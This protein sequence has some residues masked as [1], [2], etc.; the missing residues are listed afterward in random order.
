MLGCIFEML[1]IGRYV[2]IFRVLFVIK[3]KE[4]FVLEG[5]SFEEEE[6]EI[7]LRYM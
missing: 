7:F 1:V 4:G 3:M 6:V 2:G 5:I